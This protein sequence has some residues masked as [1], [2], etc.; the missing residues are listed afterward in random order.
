MITLRTVG[1]EGWRE[2]RELRLAAL[3]EAPYAFGS[4]LA[5]WQDAPEERWRQR[6]EVPHN[7][8]ADLDGVPAGMASGTAPDEYG[9]VELIS[10]WV[11]PSWRGHGVGDALVAGILSWAKAVGSGRV[12]LNVADGNT[13]AAALYRRHGFSGGS[14]RLACGAVGSSSR[15]SAGSPS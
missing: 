6:L 11:T 10:L 2:W 14:E 9:T 13:A 7:L 8:V 1:A 4:T 3:R 5:E 12:E 15:L